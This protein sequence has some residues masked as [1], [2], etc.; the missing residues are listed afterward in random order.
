MRERA[1]SIGATLEITS[2]EGAGT[3]VRA[4]L[5]RVGADLDAVSKG[6]MNMT[7]SDDP[8]TA[9][10]WCCRLRA[11]HRGHRLDREGVK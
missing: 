8:D 4:M 7:R 9:V 10:E 11:T 1:S 3:R 5:E 2:Q 6:E